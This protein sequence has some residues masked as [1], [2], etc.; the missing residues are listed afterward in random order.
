MT[1]AQD[2]AETT[3][4]VVRGPARLLSAKLFGFVGRFG[5]RDKI[6]GLPI[7]FGIVPAAVLFAI[8]ESHGDDFRGAMTTEMQVMAQ[9]VNET[10]DRNLF[11]RY[12][13]VQAFGLNAAAH[14]RGNWSNASDANPLV[15]A[16]NGYMTGYGIY[17]LMLLVS[18][19]GQVLAVNSMD[20]QGRPLDTGQYYGKSYAGTSWLS[21]AVEGRFLEGRNGFSGTV[22]EPPHRD[23]DIAQLYGEDGYVL[24]FAAPVRDGNG[25]VIGVWANFAD[26][27]LV[28]EIVAST[29]E[30]LKEDGMPTAEV[31]VLGPEGRII[32]DYDPTARGF[33]DLSEYHRDFSVIG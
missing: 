2:S 29:Y 26:F 20:G 25:Q 32:V 31:T 3:S 7:L 1:T 13:D 21:A 28:E 17:K 22:V 33:S 11:E 27:G 8:L 9:Q 10:I 19:S 16:M 30:H 12:G 5:V 15:R 6:V 24:T 23:A 18:P 14:N 4:L